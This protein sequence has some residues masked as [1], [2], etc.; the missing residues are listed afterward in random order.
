MSLAEV[1]E[2]VERW[3]PAQWQEL[4]WRLKVLELINDPEYMMEIGSRIDDARAGRC[5]SREGFRAAMAERGIVS[6]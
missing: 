4:A 5:L 3:T 6:H 1:L 2:E